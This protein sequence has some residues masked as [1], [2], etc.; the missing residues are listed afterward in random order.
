MTAAYMN[1]HAN[2]LREKKNPEEKYLPTLKDGS[3]SNFVKYS[4]YLL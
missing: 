3:L 4:G 2:L 1:W